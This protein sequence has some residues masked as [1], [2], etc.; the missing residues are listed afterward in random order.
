VE[1]N[2][3]SEVLLLA[4]LEDLLGYV[5]SVDEYFRLAPISSRLDSEGP[6]LGWKVSFVLMR[7]L[8]RKSN[9]FV[10]IAL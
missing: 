4:L 7:L 2:I 1:Q 10:D 6:A 9:N 5:R 3:V 8:S